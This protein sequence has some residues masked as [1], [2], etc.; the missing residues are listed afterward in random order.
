MPGRDVPDLLEP[1][2][3]CR[4]TAEATGAA[5]D[6]YLCHP[7]IVHTATWPHRGPQPRVI[8]QPAIHVADGFTLGGTDRHRSRKPSSRNRRHN[9]GSTPDMNYHSGIPRGG[10]LTW[11][12]TAPEGEIVGTGYYVG[13]QLKRPKPHADDPELAARL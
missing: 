1:S 11:L 2:T 10:R 9:S 8:A 3:S 6:V 13:H 4:T 5:G 12:A 7:F